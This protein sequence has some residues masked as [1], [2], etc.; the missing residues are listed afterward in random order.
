MKKVTIILVLF[1]NSFDLP[2]SLKG[3]QD[4]SQ[5]LDQAS[6]ITGLSCM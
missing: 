1:E 6:S 5:S 2:D 3:S 4:L